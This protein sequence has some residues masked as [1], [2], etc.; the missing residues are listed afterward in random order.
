MRVV[1]IFSHH[2]GQKDFFV[3]TLTAGNASCTFFFFDFPITK[4][5]GPQSHSNQRKQKAETSLVGVDDGDIC[6]ELGG[7]FF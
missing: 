6:T 4:A 1:L 2:C 5:A 7:Q 3:K